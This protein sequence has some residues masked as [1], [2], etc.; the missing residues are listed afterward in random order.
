MKLI[1]LLL[2]L[3]VQVLYAQQGIKGKIE[4]ISGNQMP[5]P[6]KQLTATKP[7]VREIFIYEATSTKQAASESGIFFSNIT[8]KLIKTVK[9]KKSGNFC[10]KL[11]PG[12]YSIFV[13]EPLGL[14]ANSFDSSG[15]IQCVT[16][17]PNE[18]T[19]V[20]ILVNYEAVY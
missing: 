3:S 13:K 12:T 8:T 11:P 6:D 4:W 17:K 2:T 10:V 14:Y 1:I 15:Y 7:I 9:S 19:Q 5:G 18:Y 20:S 16:V